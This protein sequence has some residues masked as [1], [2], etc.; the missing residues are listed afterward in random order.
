MRAKQEL[1]SFV[2]CGFKFWVN[3]S[4]YFW[5]T[6]QIPAVNGKGIGAIH[7]F[8]L[9]VWFDP[10]GGWSRYT[11]VLGI[12]MSLDKHLFCQT[13][14]ECMGDLKVPPSPTCPFILLITRN[15][16][17]KNNYKRFKKDHSPI[18]IL[19]RNSLRVIAWRLCSS[20]PSWG[21]PVLHT[22]ASETWSD[23]I[24]TKF[25]LV[26]IGKWIGYKQAWRKGA[27][28]EGVLVT[29]NFE[30]ED[31]IPPSPLA[32]HP[33]LLGPQGTPRDLGSF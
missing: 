3:I 21:P 20:R 6:C 10:W 26:V 27:N 28:W 25:L 19:L 17:F 7:Y 12:Q 18:F 23:C 16:W 2:L 29:P 22:V 30:L 14:I 8:E 11:V 33:G 9:F 13:T 15:L 24:F 1:P 31:P 32:P 5:G 4:R